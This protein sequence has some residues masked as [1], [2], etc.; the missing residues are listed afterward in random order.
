[1]PK[2]AN[3]EE[4]E[5][6]KAERVQTIKEI[7]EA[8]SKPKETPTRADT[9]HLNEKPKAST[10]RK[11]PH[12]AMII[13]SEAKICPHCRK[14]LATSTVVK[15]TLAFIII[16]VLFA[17]IVSLCT[18][19]YRGVTTSTSSVSIGQEGVLDSGSELTPVA[20]DK[21]AFDEWTKA[22]VA[23]DEQGMLQLILQGR[24][25][26]VEKN[27]RIKVIDQAMFIR[28]VRILD[29][30]HQDMAGWVAYEYIK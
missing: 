30:K 24:I 25:V 2:W 17:W 7:A 26:S 13:P 14:Q 22:R 16:L 6:W 19:T 27:T 12:C 8:Q 28:K 29:G 18:R 15:V 10:E 4:Y 3:K 11:C 20:I 1:M 9:P 21:T 23:K 5:K